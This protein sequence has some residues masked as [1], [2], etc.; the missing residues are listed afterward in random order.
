MHRYCVIVVGRWKV[1]NWH[2]YRWIEKKA[3]RN[4]STIKWHDWERIL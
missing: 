4:P 3:L 1:E 2:I